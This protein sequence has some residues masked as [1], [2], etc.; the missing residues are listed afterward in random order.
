MRFSIFYLLIVA[1]FASCG[2]QHNAPSVLNPNRQIPPR[3]T[4]AFVDQFGAFYPNDWRSV[5]GIPPRN[6]KKN[7]YSLS[8]LAEEKSL[9]NDLVKFEQ[10]YLRLLK[11]HLSN[12]KRVFV[13]IHGFNAKAKEVTKN[14]EL[15]QSKLNLTTSDEVIQFYWDGLY[16]KNPLSSLKTWFTASDY[17]QYAGKF[18]LRKI[19]N[20]ISN[21]EVYLIS[22]S[23]GAS[24]ILSA[25]SSA[26][27]DS[28]KMTDIVEHHNIDTMSLQ[29]DLI[30]NQRNKIYAIALAPAIGK[31][32]FEINHED[33][34]YNVSFTPQLMAFHIST[35]KD[36]LMLKKVVGWLSN[37]LNSTDLGYKSDSFDKLAS[38]YKFLKRS[39]FS[40]MRS[41]DFT[42]YINNP[43]FNS[44]LKTY[45]INKK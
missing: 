30:R 7:A 3:T 28:V 36:D 24:V 37:K 1:L 39:D 26:P 6:G 20:N 44:I 40:G 29:H 22:H 27:I 9:T 25:L 38:S 11:K 23:R 42:R 16:T 43:N 34:I 33:S 31:S 12:K 4:I 5:Y 13:L 21:K 14:Y 15:I 35:N 2:I 32:D 18:A 17:S 8:K 10:E 19:L 45:K 41:H